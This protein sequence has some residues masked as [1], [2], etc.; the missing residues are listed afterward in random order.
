[1]QNREKHPMSRGISNPCEIKK[2][3]HGTGDEGK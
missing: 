3:F 2:R 1:M